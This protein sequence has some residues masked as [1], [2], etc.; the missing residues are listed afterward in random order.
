MHRACDGR[1][2]RPAVD[3][4]VCGGSLAIIELGCWCV[5]FA[6]AFFA[7]AGL[8]GQKPTRWLGPYVCPIYLC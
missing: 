1:G 6:G 4:P 8:R 3:E 2:A 7:E 5:G